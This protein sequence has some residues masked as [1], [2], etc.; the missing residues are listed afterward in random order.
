MFVLW[1]FFSFFSHLPTRGEIRVLSPNLEFFLFRRR[2][3]KVSDEGLGRKNRNKEHTCTKPKMKELR[4]RR[5]SGGGNSIRIT[6]CAGRRNKEKGQ[7]VCEKFRL[8]SVDRG[9]ER[10]KV[11]WMSAHLGGG[12]KGG[13]QSIVVYT[14]QPTVP[15]I[16]CTFLCYITVRSS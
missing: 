1:Y 2:R 8:Y 12:A 7:C 15:I 4:D 11:R 14:T 10:Q 9:N 6:N 5:I 13:G 3:L 16:L